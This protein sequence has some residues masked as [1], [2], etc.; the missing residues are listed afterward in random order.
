MAREDLKAPAKY[1]GR[2]QELSA[3]EWSNMFGERMHGAVR[4]SRA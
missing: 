1:I 2:K 3:D 4:R